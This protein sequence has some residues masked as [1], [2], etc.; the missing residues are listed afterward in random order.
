GGGPRP[1]HHAASLVWGLSFS[2]AAGQYPSAMRKEGTGW[3]GPIRWSAAVTLDECRSLL[4]DHLSY[5]ARWGNPPFARGAPSGVCLGWRLAA[6][7][8]LVRTRG[9]R[10]FN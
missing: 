8:E 4:V 3:R 5:G 7:L 1:R 6:D 9:I 10:L 2:W